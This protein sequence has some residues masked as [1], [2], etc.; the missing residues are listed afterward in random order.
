MKKNIYTLLAAVAVLALAAACSKDNGHKSSP[1][2]QV[3]ITASIPEDGLQ[4]KVSLSQDAVKQPIKVE[5][6]DD[7]VITVNGETFTIDPTTISADGKSAKFTGSNPGAGPYDISYSNVS[8]FVNQTQSADGNLDHLGFEVSLTGADSYASFSFTETWA[9]AHSATYEG[10]SVLELKAALPAAI[11]SSVQKVIF[12]FPEEITPN[13]HRIYVTLGNSA[14]DADNQ[15]DVYATLPAGTINLPNILVQ[16]QVSASE[17][18]K[19]SAYREFAANNTIASGSLQ[20]LGIQCA[21]IESFANAS[22]TSIGT[23]GNPYLIGDKHQLSYM[24][25]AM[26]TDDVTYY[27]KLVDDVDWTGGVSGKTSWKNLNN[28][29]NGS[30]TWTRGVNLDGNNKTIYGL[31]DNMFYVLVG[32]VR[33]L[34]LD[35]SSI[36]I[37]AYVAGALAAYITEPNTVINNVDV[38]NSTVANNGTRAVGGIVG[39]IGINDTSNSAPLADTFATITD[40]DIT[41]TNVTG[42]PVGGLIGWANAKVLVSG[43]NYDGGTITSGDKPYAAGIVARSENYASTFTDCHVTNATVNMTGLTTAQQHYGRGGGFSGMLSTRNTVKGCTVGTS[44][45]HVKVIFPA[46]ENVNNKKN[47]NCGGFTGINYGLITKD[48]SDNHCTAYVDI[49]TATAANTE[50]H[51]GGFVGYN[52]GVIEYSDAVVSFSS[53]ASTQTNLTAGAQIGGFVGYQYNETDSQLGKIEHCT[54]SGAVSGY[55]YVGGFAGY[56]LKGGSVTASHA[57]LNDCHASVAV[58]V[59]NHYSGGLVG[60]VV[61]GTITD[62]SA[63]GNITATGKNRAGGL[64]GQ[65]EN[66]TIDH[67]HATGNVTCNAYSASFVGCVCQDPGES[68]SVTRSY[69]TGSIVGTGNQ[70]SGFVGTHVGRTTESEAGSLTITN[71]YATGDMTAQNRAGGL[72]SNHFAGTSTLENCYYAGSVT[73]TNAGGIGGIVG[74]VERDG[75][76]VTRCMVWCPSITSTVT[77][78]NQHYPLG[79]VIG[80]ANKGNSP[81]VVVDYCYRIK[82]LASNFNDCPGNAANVIEQHAFITTAAAIPQRQGLTYGYYHHGRNTNFGLTEVVAYPTFHSG[83]G[84]VIGTDW[85]PTIWN[86]SGAATDLPTLL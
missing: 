73:S 28:T 14:L 67:S 59:S 77:D 38:K 44:S 76:S 75:L 18:D 68:V 2:Q 46:A 27:F 42:G 65:I 20:Y 31:N 25:D 41:N 49:V 17:N 74:W 29:K 6:D 78:S 71:C 15:L 12:T 47:L 16:F 61:D 1:K 13:N 57:T 26:T 33:N 70:I 32:E 86:L 19:Y 4:S 36:N 9:T 24:Y 69:S 3:T 56:M 72:L 10:S 85:D 82:T 45:Q 52:T 23:V 21:N 83:S 37:G 11:K 50:L 43:C 81:K 63:S 39:R 66:G 79:A 5:W 51:L 8:D 58:T 55:G 34:T 60:Y 62:C 22:N 40:C 7:D 64:V 35:H 54:V 48:D 84:S 80:Y 53:S 30:N